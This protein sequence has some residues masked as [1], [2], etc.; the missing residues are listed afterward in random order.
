MTPKA[1][2]IDEPSKRKDKTPSWFQTGVRGRLDPPRAAGGL[3]QDDIEFVAVARG[4]DDRG[5]A[6]GCHFRLRLRTG[7]D[8]GHAGLCDEHRRVGRDGVQLH[9]ALPY[10]SD[11]LP[12]SDPDLVQRFIRATMTPCVWTA[13]SKR[14]ALGEVIK[15]S[16]DRDLDLGTGKPEIIRGLQNSPDPAERFGTMNAERFLSSIGILA[17]SGDLPTKSEPADMFANAVVES[18]PVAPEPRGS[19]PERH[20]GETCGGA[21]GGVRHRDPGRGRHLRRRL[22]RWR[23][24]P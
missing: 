14:A 13:D 12:E 6:G 5:R 19:Q 20:G 3:T 18:L 15:Q 17:A 1:S 24:R 22:A 11:D 8:A 2:G 21:R 10:A 23:R 4:A 9:G 16:P 7:P